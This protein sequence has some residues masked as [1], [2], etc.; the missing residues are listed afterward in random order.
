MDDR[1][2][3]ELLEALKKMSDGGGRLGEVPINDA[4]K[5][6]KY[7]EDLNKTVDRSRTTMGSFVKEMVTGKKR[8]V[9]L[10]ATIEDLDEQIEELSQTFSETN[11]KEIQALKDKREQLVSIQRT[12]VAFQ[13]LGGVMSTF[14][15]G[16]TNSIRIIAQGARTVARDI[17]GGADIFTT[18]ADAMDV[19]LD[20]QNEMVKT[21]ASGA[22]IAGSALM[23]LGPVGIA[24]GAALQLAAF[25]ATTY[26]EMMTEAQKFYNHFVL[27]EGSKILKAFQT[28]SSAGAMYAGGAT[29]MGN[30][31]RQ[32]GLSLEQFSNSVQ[33]NAHNLAIS[34]VGVSE[35]AELMSNAMRHLTDNGGKASRQLLNL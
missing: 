29:T 12:N 31:A 1:Q 24:V 30:L 11:L 21:L 4:V 9:D 14:G 25:A 5:F 22:N 3:Q 16:I 35:G 6:K 7:I 26:S 2:I 32:A 18:V 19:Q 13:A 8:Y 17:T 33:K 27:T 34:G 28:M 23:T 20:I 10:S 15:Q